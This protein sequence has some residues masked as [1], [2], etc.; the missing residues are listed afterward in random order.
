MVSRCYSKKNVYYKHYGGR[1]IRICNEWLNDFLKFE[2]WSYQNGY[3]DGLTIDRINV[4]GDYCPSNCRFI[5]TQEQS[6]NRRSN[7]LNKELIYK[8]LH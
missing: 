7:I 2:Q 1:G 6:Q 8:I 3:K 5:T 4:N